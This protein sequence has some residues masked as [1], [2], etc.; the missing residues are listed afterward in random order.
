MA[1][2]IRKKINSNRSSSKGRN[3][4]YNFH[5]PSATQHCMRMPNQ[6]AKLQ[7][8]TNAMWLLRKLSLAVHVTTTFAYAAPRQYIMTQPR[9]LTRYRMP[10]QKSLK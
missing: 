9:S 5:V 4:W 3:Q 10:V 7:F 2:L 8:V 1:L 6:G